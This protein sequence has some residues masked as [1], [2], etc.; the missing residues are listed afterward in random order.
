MP[1]AR[2]PTKVAFIG[3]GSQHWAPHLIRDLIFKEGLEKVQLELALLDLDLS[4][5][6]AIKRLFDVQMKRWGVE[7]VHTY[8]TREATR[9]LKSADFVLIAVSTGGLAAMQHDLEIPERY[10]IF[11]TVGDTSGPGGWARTLRNIPV[12]LSFARQ[13][14]ELAPNAFVLNYTNPMGALTKVLAD[15]LGQHRVIGL[16]HGLFEVYEV[17]QKLFRLERE[18]QIKA[19]FGGLNHF[20]WLLDF[21]INGTDGYTLLKKKL[22]GRPLVRA[23]HEVL[24]PTGCWLASELYE[25]YGHL[26]YLADRHTSEFFSCYLTDPKMMERFHLV[27]TS[28]EDRR[29]NYARDAES[30]RLWTEGKKTLSKT[31]SRETA[32]DIMAAII[33]DQG[34]TDVMNMV[35]IGQITNLPLGAVVETMGYVD[36][37]GAKPLTLGPLPEPLRVLCAPHAEGQL[38]TVAAGLSGDLEAALLA[39]AAD[40]LCAQLTIS[41][42]KRMGRELLEANRQYL[43]QFFGEKTPHARQKITRRR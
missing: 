18:D 20:F 16:C 39:L 7:R 33:F 9:A 22:R 38:R 28:I 41:D 13:I 19:R 32:A 11:H 29:K 14:R 6:Q 5:A 10:G 43:P 27:R 37:G 42:V 25:H 21:S 23:I 17:L 26:C 35:N 3:G 12:F 34:F 15:E 1:R 24:G 40:P 36:Q 30:V 8:A 4:R 2:K 31:P